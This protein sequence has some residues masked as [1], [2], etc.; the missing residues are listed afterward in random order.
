MVFSFLFILVKSSGWVCVFPGMSDAFDASPPAKPAVLT[1]NN[2]E[3]CVS[4]V[5]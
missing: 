2:I 1:V 4:L 5:Q 3:F